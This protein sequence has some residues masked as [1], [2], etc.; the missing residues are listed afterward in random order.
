M[1]IKIEFQCPECQEFCYKDIKKEVLNINPNCRS[2]KKTM[3]FFKVI[4]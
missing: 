3:V 2:C 4:K 1:G